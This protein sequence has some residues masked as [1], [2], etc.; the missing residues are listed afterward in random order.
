MSCPYK[1]AVPGDCHISC[2]RKFSPEEV[3]PDFFQAL[4]LLP[5]HAGVWPY[6]FNEGFVC[7]VCPYKDEEKDESKTRE[8]DPMAMFLAMTGR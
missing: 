8:L 5:G 2:T 6:L 7:Y 3:T 4:K 1:K